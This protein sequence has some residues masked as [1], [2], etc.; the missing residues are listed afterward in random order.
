MQ[1]EWARS[2][3]MSEPT[4]GSLA[5]FDQGMLVTPPKGLEYG[6]VPIVI[7]QYISPNA[8]RI[9][10]ELAA[11]K[12][13]AEAKAAAELKAKQEAEAKA[14]AVAEL[15]AQKAE[16]DR[17]AKAAAEL[18]AKQDAE[19]KAAA[20]LKA[21]QEAEAKAAATTLKKKTITCI[22]GKLVKKVT[23]IKPVCPKGY[24]LKK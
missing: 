22:K 2:A 16:A 15:A 17:S 24:K 10:A 13:E 20:E 6:Y 1:K 23:T 4:K 12:A 7:K 9:A 14:K 5:T 11:Q 21:K 3:L 18:K 8:D 19:A